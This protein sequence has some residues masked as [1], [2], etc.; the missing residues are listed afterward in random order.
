[1]EDA[2]SEEVYPLVIREMTRMHCKIPANG[3]LKGDGGDVVVN[4]EEVM[5]SKM[6]N[7]IKTFNALVEDI[8]KINPSLVKRYIV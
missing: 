1:M 8:L 4:G 6:W 7:K 5:E 2:R 3:I